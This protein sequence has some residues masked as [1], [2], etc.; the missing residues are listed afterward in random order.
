MNDVRKNPSKWIAKIDET[1]LKKMDKD[2]VTHKDWKRKFKEG[3]PAMK[4]AKNFLKNAKPVPTLKLNVGMSYAAFKHSIFMLGKGKL[5][6]TGKG[7][8]SMS[9]RLEE[10]GDWETTIGENILKTSNN[11]KKPEIIVMEWLIDDGVKNR[12]HRQ[13]LL[14]KDFKVIGIGIANNPKDKQDWITVDLSGGFNCKKCS[15][16]TKVNAKEMGWNGPM[17]S[18]SG[19]SSFRRI[20]GRG[21]ACL[22]A[23][24]AVYLVGW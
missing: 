14:K 5:D 13:N 3:V 21:L 23:F 19:S 1:Y 20:V 9:N 24:V 11:T 4:E 7:G 15:K 2:N 22:G 17:P 6:H 10:Y 12:G 18:S 8:S 16:L